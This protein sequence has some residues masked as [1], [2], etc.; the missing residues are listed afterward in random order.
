MEGTHT[1]RK[2]LCHEGGKIRRRGDLAFEGVEHVEFVVSP[3][4][5]FL[6]L[7]QLDIFVQQGHGEPVLREAYANLCADGCEEFLVVRGEVTVRFIDDL[8]DGDELSLDVE[9]GRTEART[10][11]KP[12]ALVDGPVEKRGLIDV[13]DVEPLPSLGDGSGDALSDGEPDWPR[14]FRN[15]RIE[16]WRA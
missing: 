11:H 13:L 5:F 6:G 2:R 8:Y 12:G 9:D 15:D 4:Q 1:S 14:A 10:R 7:G 16:A 3:A